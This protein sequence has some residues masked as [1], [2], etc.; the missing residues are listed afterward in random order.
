MTDFENYMKMNVNYEYL[1]KYYKIEDIASIYG[2]SK[3][4][5]KHS[6]VLSWILNPKAGEAIDYLPIRN[7]LKLIQG[8]NSYYEFFN[9]LDLNI[10]RIDK[11]TIQREKY[12]IDLLITLRINNENYV[13]VIEN[14]LEALIHDNQ[15]EVYKAKVEKVYSNYKKLYVFLHPGI[16]PVSEKEANDN[17][18]VT[19]TYQDVYDYILK[20]LLEFSTDSKVKLIVS[21]YIHSLCCYDSNNLIGLAVTDEER[22]ALE[23]LFA[24]A[25][26][27]S[28]I[29]SLCNNVKNEYTDYYKH[30]KSA[31][32]KIFNK[33]L[34]IIEDET[35]RAEIEKVLKTK[36]Y[37]LNGSPY[38]GIA[39]LL[40]E[41]IEFLLQ[42]Y[43]IE[44]LHEMVYLMSEVDPLLVSEED[45]L[46]VEHKSWYLDYPKT[47]NYNGCKY[48]ILSSW[49]SDEYDILK[50]KVNELSRINPE[51]YGSITLE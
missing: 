13:I 9:T 14:K 38:R 3:Y 46:K 25:Q 28:M 2:V 7:L 29:E 5:I 39:Q 33:Y 10:A 49:A 16:N 19:I 37:L 15:L 24:D 12:N 17:Q 48:Y 42:T 23:N 20:A 36:S 8:K 44:E 51:I 4:E 30:N 1:Q 18:Y 11:V 34:H 31:F 41:L 22:K 47:I 21:F 26:I 45:L 6:N 43:T 27:L 32:I 35:L 40:Q 50:D